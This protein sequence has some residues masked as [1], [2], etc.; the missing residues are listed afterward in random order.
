[1]EG[2]PLM[3][4][5][6][7]SANAPHVVPGQCKLCA[8]L[9]GDHANGS[10]RR[11]LPE[12][13]FATRVLFRNGSMCAMPSFGSLSPGH[14][15]VCTSFHTLS[16][17]SALRSERL[18]PGQAVDALSSYEQ[19]LSEIYGL[20]CIVFE[21]GP[22]KPG[23]EIGCTADHAHLHVVPV[24]R[25]P[26]AAVLGD[27]NDWQPI[28]GLVALPQ[29]VRETEEYFLFRGTDRR[30][31]VARNPTVAG[32]QHL[33]RVLAREFG[34]ESLWDWRRHPEAA[35]VEE[36]LE[37][38]SQVQRASTDP[39]AEVDPSVPGSGPIPRSL[40]PLA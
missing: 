28:E 8:D 25:D 19:S 36:F 7:R 5:S 17:A 20:R 22:A 30:W 24:E 11:F 2:R 23:S 6:I 10:Y 3:C 29:I 15:L 4:A 40:S 35:L 12:S 33:R 18:T 37:L 14:S 16:W 31:H 13:R 38:W 21:H 1:M 32:S 26:V 34:R 9:S 39:H 27:G